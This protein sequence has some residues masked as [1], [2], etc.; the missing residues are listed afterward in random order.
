[1]YDLGNVGVFIVPADDADLFGEVLVIS[2]KVGEG[3]GVHPEGPC[4]RRD[5]ADAVG[6]FVGYLGFT[7]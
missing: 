7:G 4:I 6:E 5:V 2:F 1:M 3:V